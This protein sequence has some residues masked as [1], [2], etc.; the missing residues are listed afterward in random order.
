MSA[1][2]WFKF[3][4]VFFCFVIVAVFLQRR[5]ITQ[6]YV[7]AESFYS[8]YRSKSTQT[9]ICRITSSF[10]RAPASEKR[11]IVDSRSLAS[12]RHTYTAIRSWWQCKIL[13]QYNHKKEEWKHIV[14]SHQWIYM[15]KYA[16]SRTHDTSPHKN[17]NAF[18]LYTPCSVES[19]NFVAYIVSLSHPATVCAN[20]LMANTPLFQF[21]RRFEY[22]RFTHFF[23]WW[24]VWWHIDWACGHMSV[25]R[26][27]T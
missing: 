24:I 9:V 18:P 6:E 27:P 12:D 19:R 23:V 20:L 10:S 4:F 13:K 25:V 11:K 14:K 26:S 15:Y 3:C 7:G 16:R 8:I 2:N 17:V 21:S 22:E 5:K 1:C